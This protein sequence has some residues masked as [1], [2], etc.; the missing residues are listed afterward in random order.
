MKIL[1]AVDGSPVSTRAAKH[2]IDLTRKM[3]APPELVLLNADPPLLQAAAVKIGIEGVKRYH[4]E[5]GEYATRSARAALTRAQVP[6]TEMLVV[7]EPA[8]AIIDEAGKG[9]HDLIVMGSHG[10]GAIKGLLLGSVTSK[11]IA[12]CD[13]PVTVVR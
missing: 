10:R 13:T 12:N 11:V 3:S 8:E 7:A 1:L 4:Q 9:R 2:V 6:F 5:N